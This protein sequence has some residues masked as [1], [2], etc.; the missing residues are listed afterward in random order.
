MKFI[1]LHDTSIFVVKISAG[2]SG[3]FKAM[4]SS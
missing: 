3:G 4:E 1:K 2:L